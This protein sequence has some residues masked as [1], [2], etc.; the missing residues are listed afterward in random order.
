M[1]PEMQGASIALIAVA[2]I[3]LGAILGKTMLDLGRAA[4]G[5]TRL[6]DDFST[7]IPRFKTTLGRADELIDRLE[8]TAGHVEAIGQDARDEV[9]GLLGDIDRL[10][11]NGR[12]VSAIVQGAKAGIDA[13]RSAR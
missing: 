7:L 10:R 1:S 11:E 2:G 12:Q 3:A 4:R 5:V 13:F 6:C 9:H 8:A